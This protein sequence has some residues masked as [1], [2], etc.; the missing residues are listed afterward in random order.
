LGN[1]FSDGWNWYDLITFF[2]AMIYSIKR[3]M[4]PTACYSINDTTRPI[5]E[6]VLTWI[7]VIKL[8]ILI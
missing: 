4:D 3:I 7:V 5:E 6:A 1:Y 8:I 2:L